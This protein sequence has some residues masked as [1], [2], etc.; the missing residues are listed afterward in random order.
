MAMGG[1]GTGDWGLGTGDWGRKLV[2]TKGIFCGKLRVLVMEVAIS[3]AA[4][5]EDG[6]MEAG[7]GVGKEGGGGVEVELCRALSNN[8][9]AIPL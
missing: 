4:G 6:W 1:L 8:S 3:M 2:E 5:W 9:T 7:L